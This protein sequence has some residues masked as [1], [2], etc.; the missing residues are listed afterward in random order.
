MRTIDLTTNI[1]APL[2]MGQIITFGSPLAG[3][4]FISSWNFISALIE[5]FLLYTIYNN[6]PELGEK[7]VETTTTVQSFKE[8]FKGWGLYFQHPICFAGLAFAVLFMTVMGFDSITLGK[9]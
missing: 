3:T 6:V 1:L 8:I 4:I 7:S 5:Y 9:Y 2:I